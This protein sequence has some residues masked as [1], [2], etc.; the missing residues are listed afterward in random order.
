M[1][2]TPGDGLEARG[3]TM[4]NL[5]A[6][7]WDIHWDHVDEMILGAPKWFDTARF[8]ILAKP[9]SATNASPP[10]RIDDDLRLM[11]RALLIDRF[12]IKTHYEDR[13]VDA[14][15][16]VAAKPRLK[17]AD[18]ANRANCKEAHTVENDPRDLNPRLSRLLACQ[19][20]TLAQFAEQ[21]LALSPNDFAYSVIDATGIA[22]RWDFTLSFTPTGD[23]RNPGGA[24]AQPGEG[25]TAPDPSGAMSI[26]EAIN[27]QLGLKLELHKRRLPV[28]VI[29][30]IEEKPTE[31]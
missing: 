26:F 3:E 28:L 5:F 7:A 14:Y 25:T 18:P 1:G 9:P 31:N 8:E 4:R 12:K 16:L 29:D 24:A 15:T 30:H 27:K 10:P 13:L 21:L 19:N 17:K 22:G 6:T 20:I 23:R 2:I 11:L